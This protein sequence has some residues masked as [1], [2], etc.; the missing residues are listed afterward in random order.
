MTAP[1]T[2]GHTAA[3]DLTDGGVTDIDVAIVGAGF[4]GLGMGIRLAR[5]GRESFVLLE[6]AAEVGGTWRDNTYPGVACDIPSHLYSFS[7]RPRPDWS[8]VFAPGSEIQEYLREAA[9]AEGLLPHLRFG[10]DMHE[11]RWEGD[12]WRIT[13]GAGTWRARVLVM[14][15][16]RLSEPR[17]P[18]LPGLESFPGPVFHTSR[19]DPGA[20]LTGR[21]GV[22]GTGA[23]A[24]QV[25]PGLAERA[26]QLVVFQRS[27]PWVV[28]RNDRAYSPEELRELADPAHAA[29]VRD[30]MFA[31]AERNFPQRLGRHPDI[32]RL[33]DTAE[34]HLAAQ[35]PD[36][37]LRALLTPDYEIGC[38]RV[39]LSDDL[40]PALAREN[41]TLEPSALTAIEGG[42]AVAG[43]GARHDVDALVVATG[44]R[45]TDPP[46]AQRVVG[47]TGLLAEHWSAGMTAYASTVVHGFPNLFVLDGPNASLGHNSAVHMIETQ[48]GYVEGAL[49]HLARSAE[50]LEVSRAA[51]AGYTAEIDARSRDTVWL[52]GG[53]RSWYVDPRSGRLTLLWPGT[54]GSFRERNGRFDPSPFGH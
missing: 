9:R 15:A 28:P 37:R 7:F 5:R 14:A 8:R 52:R 26:S 35:V 17:M 31:D 33:R 10:A 16:G 22:V 39:L 53:C 13:T 6:R 46:F 32:D 45:S 36:P 34:H 49:D 54:A 25:I 41:V 4:A 20:D 2:D 24:A 42:K 40:Y 19:W 38:K 47:R 18:E 3:G 51:E 27:A 23:S 44:F 11:A 21:V 50:P 29:R 48:I 43:S 1:T 12:R 30:G